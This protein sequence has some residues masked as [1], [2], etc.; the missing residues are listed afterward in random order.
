[1]QNSWIRKSGLA[2]CGLT[3][4]A[5]AWGQ[6]TTATFYGTVTDPTGAVIPGATVTLLN[7]ETGASLSPDIFVARF[8]YA[9]EH[10]AVE[11]NDRPAFASAPT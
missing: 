3:L 4:A 6:V 11:A 9:G 10:A 2:A 1:M 8:L 5:M 7:E